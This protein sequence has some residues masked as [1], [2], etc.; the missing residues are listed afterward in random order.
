MNLFHFNFHEVSAKLYNNQDAVTLMDSNLVRES[1]LGVKQF[2]Y[3]LLTQASMLH[4][5]GNTGYQD[6]RGNVLTGS[7]INEIHCKHQLQML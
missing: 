2:K 1:F 5:C 7:Q 4:Y 3:A 6:R